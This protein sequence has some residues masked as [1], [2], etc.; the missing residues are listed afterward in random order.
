MAICPADADPHRFPP[1]TEIGQIFHNKNLQKK[2]FK[3][4]SGEWLGQTNASPPLISGIRHAL[5]FSSGKTTCRCLRY[6][7]GNAVNSQRRSRDHMIA[8]R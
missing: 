4:K 3:L 7:V 2:L 1:F 5:S 6:T 8:G